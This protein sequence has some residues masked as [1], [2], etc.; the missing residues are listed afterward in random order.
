M[1]RRRWQETLQDGTGL[2]STKMVAWCSRVKLSLTMPIV[3]FISDVEMQK[4]GKADSKGATGTQEVPSN[5]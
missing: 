5:D 4:W 2:R 3:V 1:R